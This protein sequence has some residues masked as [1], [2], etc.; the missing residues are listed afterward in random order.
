MKHLSVSA[1]VILA[2]IVPLAWSLSCYTDPTDFK[3]SEDCN[4]HTGCIKKFMPKTQKTIERGCFLVPDNDTC[5][6]EP[7]TGLGVCYCT[8]DLCNGGVHTH[9]S[10]L[11]TFGT[12]LGLLL[13]LNFYLLVIWSVS[14]KNVQFTPQ[15]VFSILSQIIA[16]IWKKHSLCVEEKNIDFKNRVKFMKKNSCCYN[17]HDISMTK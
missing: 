17:Y 5:F 9:S 1:A 4:M 11:G 3:I 8:T 10:I 7:D 12:I 15:N 6:I 16:W 2:T 13:P 14:K